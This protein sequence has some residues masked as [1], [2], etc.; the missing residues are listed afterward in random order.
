MTC[1]DSCSFYIHTLQVY[2]MRWH[3]K[4]N[5]VWG[6]LGLA[7][8]VDLLFQRMRLHVLAH[9]VFAW[10]R[11]TNFRM[12]RSSA[13][14]VNSSGVAKIQPQKKTPPLMTNTTQRRPFGSFPPKKS[15][16]RQATSTVCNESTNTTRATNSGIVIQRSRAL[17][18]FVCGILRLVPDIVVNV[19]RFWCDA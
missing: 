6:M 15:S 17:M 8:C 16:P 9:C 5:L 18:I 13:P 19:N 3:E 11:G 12:F 2:H 4:A 7:V 14:T 1:S 10:F